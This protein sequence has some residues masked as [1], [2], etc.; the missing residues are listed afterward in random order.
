MIDVNKNPSASELREHTLAEIESAAEEAMQIKID[1]ESQIKQA[2]ARAHKTGEFADP[3]W[4]SAAQTKLKYVKWTYQKCLRVAG[5]KR[6][7]PKA[8]HKDWFIK[9]AREMLDEETFDAIKDR[10][11]ELAGELE[12]A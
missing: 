1:I 4:F 2:K 12:M 9:A 7:Q 8:H 10:A 11:L 6:K 3:D 5:E